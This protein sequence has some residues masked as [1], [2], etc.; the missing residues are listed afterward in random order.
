M[1]RPAVAPT[2]DTNSD[3]TIV[4]KATIE[5]ARILGLTNI[6]LARVLGIS[7]SQVS[8][9]SHGRAVLDGKAVE[10]GLWF[11]R[12]FRGLSGIVGSD[13]ASAQSWM[14]TENIPLRGKPIDLIQN[15]GGLIN[16]VAYVDTFRARI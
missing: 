1:A 12:L 3:A 9:V 7:E 15:V 5:S 6:E 10:L 2:A 8:R 16:T 14:R 13:D 4:S 11:V